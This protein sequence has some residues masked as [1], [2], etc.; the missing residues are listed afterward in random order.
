MTAAPRI[1]RGVPAAELDAFL[2]SLGQKE[3]LAA[4]AECWVARQGHDIVAGLATYRR[5]DLHAAPGVNGLVGHYGARDAAAGVALLRAAAAALAADGATR[6]L[7]PMNG[8][9]WARYRFALAPETPDEASE[10]PYLSEPVNPT[11]YLDQF[12]AARFAP[13]VE[14]ESRI[15]RD[16]QIVDPKAQPA[17]AKVAAAGI[18]I[19]PLALARLEA[20]LEE[21]HALSLE[22]FRD[23]AYYRPIAREAFVAM[24]TPLRPL[25][26]P[27]LVELARDAEGRLLGFSFAFVD[28]LG[29]AAGAP[30]R[31]VLKTLA[32][33]PALRGLGLGTLL[34]DR[35]RSLAL[36]KGHRAV[37][38]ALMHLSNASKRM[39][40]RTTTRFRRYALFAWSGL[41]G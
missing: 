21:I 1:E 30:G 12:A 4:D 27:D 20:T 6:V 25:L 2:L 3:P 17:A 22:A 37:I 13:I 5:D 24:Y 11:A 18:R 14:Y 29:A 31:V 26:D 32:T 38:H 40:E 33:S 23:N 16:L 35:A 19:E 28:P 15:Q 7:G 9:T 41:P 39:S 36:A 10:P 8:S 34:L